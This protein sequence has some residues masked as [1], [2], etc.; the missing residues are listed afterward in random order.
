MNKDRKNASS[1]SDEGAGSFIE[2]NTEEGHYAKAPKEEC[3]S[4]PLRLKERSANHF[5][6]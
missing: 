5:L 3:A 6:F 4:T 2:W 1:G